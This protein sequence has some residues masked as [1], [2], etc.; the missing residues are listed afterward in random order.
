MID[1]RTMFKAPRDPVAERMYLYH[2]LAA[3]EACF[4]AEAAELNLGL[5]ENTLAHRQMREERYWS[6]LSDFFLQERRYHIW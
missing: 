3:T 6:A 5:G 4:C 1:V 2:T